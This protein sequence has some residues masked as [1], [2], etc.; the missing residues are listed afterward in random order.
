M[1]ILK[2][3]QVY[4][5]D[6]N[7]TIYTYKT[8]DGSSSVFVVVQQPIPNS[9]NIIQVTLK[10]DFQTARQGHFTPSASKSPYQPYR[11]PQPVYSERMDKPGSSS[12]LGTGK[13]SVY[14]HPFVYRFV[15]AIILNHKLI[16]VTYMNYH[17]LKLFLAGKPV[18]FK[19]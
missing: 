10:Q 2:M 19:L 14:T 9:D 4:N 11:L 1:T 17:N 3:K 8:E 7:N 18:E 5:I 6:L 12:R 13:S 15:E 16:T